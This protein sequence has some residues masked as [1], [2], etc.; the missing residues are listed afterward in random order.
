M[1]RGASFLDSRDW[2]KAEPVELS[3]NTYP[4]G[5]CKKT[6][7]NHWFLDSCQAIA[8]SSSSSYQA[9]PYLRSKASLA[10]R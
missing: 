3:L 6:F 4:S 8:N 9:L 7:L 2:P 10:K 1:T 5:H